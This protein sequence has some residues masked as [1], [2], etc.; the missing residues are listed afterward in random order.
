[1]SGVTQGS[2]IEFIKNAEEAT[3]P[4]KA[5][6]HDACFDLYASENVHLLKD[7]PTAV[8]VGYNIAVPRGYVGLVCSRSGLAA[9]HGVFVLNAPGVVD[10]G[11]RGPLKVIL[12]NS[13]PHPR[14]DIKVGDRIGQLLLQKLVPSAI[15]EVDSFSDAETSRGE[16]GFGSSGV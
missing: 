14:H 12:C 10:A 16:K 4:T 9:K 6:P 5:H 3:L 7:F 1:M 8:S 11:Y 2:V 13:G 15:V